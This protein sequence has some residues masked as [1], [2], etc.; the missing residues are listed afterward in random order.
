M[1][2]THP[3]DLYSTYQVDALT[4]VRTNPIDPARLQG[5]MMISKHTVNEQ[6][7]YRIEIHGQ[8]NPDWSDWFEGLALTHECASDGSPITVLTGSFIDQAALH[9]VLDEIRDLNLKLISVTPLDPV[10]PE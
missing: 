3:V 5:A 4:R 10:E 1:M 9:G 2:T 7:T 6:R 8:L